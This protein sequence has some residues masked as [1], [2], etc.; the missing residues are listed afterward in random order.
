MSLIL[1][2]ISHR[3][4]HELIL[5][6]VSLTVAAGEIVC[7]LG[8]SGSGKSTLLRIAAGLESLQAGEVRLGDSVLADARHSVPPER[9]SV[10][11]VFQDHVLFPHLSVADNVAFGLRGISASE[12]QRI[13]RGRLEEVGLS[14]FADRYPHT[15]SGGQQQRVALARALA[16]EPDAMLLDEPFAS[17]DATLRRRLRE[18]ARRALQAN[19]CP[20]IVVTHDPDEALELADRIAVM[21]DGRIAQSGEPEALWRAPAN[22]FVAEL[23]GDAQA[24]S[25]HLEGNRVQTAFGTVAAPPEAALDA[26]AVQVMVRPGGAQLTPG[27]GN[28]EVRDV[29]FLGDRYLTIVSAGIDNLRT[30]SV[31]KP[32]LKRGDPVQV[33]LRDEEVLVYKG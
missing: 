13:V 7:L 16:P 20:A 26:G 23:F 33:T 18:D 6:G 29:R 21:I 5:D 24:I 12:R 2:D 31:E 4:D 17:V 22:R 32:A 30:L 15:L 1:S 19:G 11:L 28:A 9:R 10:G 8:P 25:G 27:P 3:Y 14:A